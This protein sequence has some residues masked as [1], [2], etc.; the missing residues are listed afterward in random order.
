MERQRPKAAAAALLSPPTCTQP[1]RQLKAL[2]PAHTK[3]HRG[4]AGA[5]CVAFPHQCHQT[6]SLPRTGGDRRLTFCDSLHLHL[7]SDKL[8][9]FLQPPE[10]VLEPSYGCAYFPKHPRARVGDRGPLSSTVP[11]THAPW[12]HSGHESTGSL[13]TSSSARAQSSGQDVDGHAPAEA[14]RCN[15]IRETAKTH[16]GEPLLKIKPRRQ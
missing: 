7:H 1:P 11:C 16:L 13:L 6:A 10:A 12:S 9:D 8:Q 3:P 4:A 2:L 5:A 15:T 14:R